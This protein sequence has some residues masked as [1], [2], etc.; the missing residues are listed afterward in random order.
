[1]LVWDLVTA[2]RSPPPPPKP[3]RRPAAHSRRGFVRAFHHRRPAPK[4]APSGPGAIPEEL[5][6]GSTRVSHVPQRDRA[7]PPAA[8]EDAPPF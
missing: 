7:V 5:A 6:P 8:R 2:R 1:M 4:P 3:P